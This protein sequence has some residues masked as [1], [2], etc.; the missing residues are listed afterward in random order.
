VGARCKLSRQASKELALWKE[1]GTQEKINQLL[2]YKTTKH[3]NNN[4]KK[5]QPSRELKL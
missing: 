3:L 5:N 1:E 4:Q 2:Q